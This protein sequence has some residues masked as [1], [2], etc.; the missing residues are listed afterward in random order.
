MAK[1]AAKNG[2]EQE[3][4]K[5]KSIRDYVTANPDEGPTAVAAAL[6]ARVGTAGR[7]SVG[8]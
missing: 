2:D 4:N 3:I 6:N 1:K 8:R 7:Y 5:S